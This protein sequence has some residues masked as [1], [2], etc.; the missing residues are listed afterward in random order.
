MNSSTFSLMHFHICMCIIDPDPLAPPPS[1]SFL[2]VVYY[3][4]T[5]GSNVQLQSILAAVADYQAQNGLDKSF[6]VDLGGFVLEGA[7]DGPISVPPNT[8]VHGGTVILECQGPGAGHVWRL[9]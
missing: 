8:T 5:I 9:L 7:M 2:Q 3:R 6:L 1:P 4:M